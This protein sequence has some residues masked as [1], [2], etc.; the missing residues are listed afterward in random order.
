MIRELRLEIANGI[1]T[2]TIDR[3]KVR[4]AI[5]LAMW[6]AIPTLMETVTQD[7][8]VRAIVFRGAG[9]QAFAS[10][11]DISEFEK[12]RRDAATAQAYNQTVDTALAA[13]RSCPKPTVAMIFGHCVGGGLELALALDLRFAADTA[14]FAIP[15]ARLGLAYG[16]DSTSCL[17]RLVGP[18]RAK[19]ILFSGRTF[20]AGEA[21]EMGFVNRVLP[22][23]AL[24]S[25][26]DDY[27]RQVAAN[28]PL[29]IRGAKAM[30]EG[31]TSGD[32][33]A[34]EIRQIV[35][36]IFDSHDYREGVRAFLEKRTPRFEGR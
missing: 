18:A 34:Q 22:A 19:E 8:T 28:A 36:E 14:R 13:L 21:A 30:I 6:E 25:Y 26:T 4:N 12:V 10:G 15:A 31:I 23:R 29:S 2:I 20:D 27:L 16:L 5:T 7:A 32:L 11:A 24:E 35:S 9:E 17:V 1:A 3:P 33:N